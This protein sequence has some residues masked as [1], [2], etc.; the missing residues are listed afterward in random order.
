MPDT[1]ADLRVAGVKLW[2][3]TGDKMATAINIGYSARL[4]DAA[5]TKIV[6]KADEDENPSEESTALSLDALLT[7]TLI[8]L[9]AQIDKL[10]T[11]FEQLADPDPA[12]PFEEGHEEKSLGKLASDAAKKAMPCLGDGDDDETMR[13][14]TTPLLE[15]YVGGS[16]GW[17]GG[18]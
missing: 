2:V 4:L 7:K 14:R 18:A 9:E 5:M 13:S 3:L 15:K 1:I 12:S 17:G 16:V 10:H 6:I 11:H 8:K